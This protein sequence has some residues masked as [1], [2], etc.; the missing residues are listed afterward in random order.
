MNLSQRQ[1]RLFVV[2]AERLNLSR[3]AEAL[4][5][6]QPA[7]TRALQ[8]FESQLGVTLFHRST[9][10]ISLTADG[11]RLLPQAQRLLHDLEHLAGEARER[12]AGISGQ[13]QLAVG[14]AFGCTVLAQA[15]RPFAASHP[16]V[17]V[18]VVDANSAEITRRVAEAQADLGIGTPLG[19]VER[20]DCQPLLH[21]PIGVLHHPALIRLRAPLTAAQLEALPLLKEPEDTSIAQALRARGSGLVARMAGGTEVSS[22]ALQ[23]AFA[24]AGA[25]VAVVSA[26]GASHPA[27]AGLRFVPLQPPVERT[28]FLMRR[29][30]R[31]LAPPAL[32]LIEALRAALEGATLHRA[33]RR[34]VHSK[35]ECA[36]EN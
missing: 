23:L 15:L 36:A 35:P 4:H 11:E 13:V 29:R 9:R 2:C 32:A 33:V 34:A 20:L 24:Q 12:A 5:L 7:L 8:E 16:R 3:A 10:R 31:V 25:G 26:L 22:L 14:Q 28:V 19:D 1:L 21:A 27:A 6:S 18:T 30:D 17:R